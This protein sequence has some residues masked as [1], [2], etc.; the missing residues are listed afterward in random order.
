VWFQVAEFVAYRNFVDYGIPPGINK[1]FATT[2]AYPFEIAVEFVFYA[3][4][5]LPARDIYFAVSKG[6]RRAAPVSQLSA[7]RTLRPG[8]CRGI[9]SRH[10]FAPLIS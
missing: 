7:A 9:P 2:R 4:R 6:S 10:L 1:V 5:N 8:L 3:H